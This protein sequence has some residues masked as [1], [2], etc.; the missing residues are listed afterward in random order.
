[1]SILRAVWGFVLAVALMG[2]AVSNRQDATLVFSPVHEPLQIPLYIIALLFMAA[3]FILGAVTMWFNGAKSRKLKRQQRKT[4][5]TLEKELAGAKKAKNEPA[6]P[7]S[8]FFPALP[9]NKNSSI[10]QE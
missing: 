9:D 7:P 1:M 10:K 3:G 6:E 2:F 4:I 5:K 8:D